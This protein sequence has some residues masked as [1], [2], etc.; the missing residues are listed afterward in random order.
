VSEHAASDVAEMAAATAGLAGMVKTRVRRVYREIDELRRL[1]A[2]LEHT[3]ALV[4]RAAATDAERE[5][6][7]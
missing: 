3:A 4:E 1:C 2:Q 6:I 7:A 5:R